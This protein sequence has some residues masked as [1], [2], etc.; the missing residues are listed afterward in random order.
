MIQRAL[1]KVVLGYTRPSEKAEWDEITT[2]DEQEVTYHAGVFQ[3]EGGNPHKAAADLALEAV[4]GKPEIWMN[5]YAHVKSVEY[6]GSVVVE[7]EGG[8]TDG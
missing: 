6:V 7:D 5:W 3:G 1:Y 4:V 8:E 2:F